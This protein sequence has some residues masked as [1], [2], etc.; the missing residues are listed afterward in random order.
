MPLPS[1]IQ[2]NTI[3]HNTEKV[4]EELFSRTQKEVVKIL[5]FLAEDDRE[6][7]I[8]YTDL[9]AKQLVQKDWQLQHRVAEDRIAFQKKVESFR[10]GVFWFVAIAG[11]VVGIAISFFVAK[12]YFFPPYSQEEW[13]EHEIAQLKEDH[14]QEIEKLRANLP[15]TADWKVDSDALLEGDRYP[16]RTMTLNDGTVCFRRESSA[17]IICSLPD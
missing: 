8:L 7:L 16:F 11:I 2:K 5:D 9:Y 1:K 17:S 12:I 13:M 10:E 6:K 3:A 4:E 15:S 14:Q